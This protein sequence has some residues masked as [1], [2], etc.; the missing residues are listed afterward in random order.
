MYTAIGVASLNVVLNIL[1]VPSLGIVGAALATS[2][3]YTFNAVV[4]VILY[5]RLSGGGVS[6]LFIP[7]PGD[8]DRAMALVKRA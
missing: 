1:L 4:K 8:L 3:A 2:L 6:E 7:R 5:T